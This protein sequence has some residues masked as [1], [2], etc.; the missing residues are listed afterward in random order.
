MTKVYVK[1][2]STM[3]KDI[4]IYKFQKDDEKRLACWD[5]RLCKITNKDFNSWYNAVRDQRTPC[6]LIKYDTTK[7]LINGVFQQLTIK[8]Y[9]AKIINI[10]NTLKKETNGKINMY[11]SGRFSKT[12]LEFYFTE[13][14]NKYDIELDHISYEEAIII[15]KAS[16]GPL[17]ISKKCLNIKAWSYDF[18]SCYPSIMR[19][20]KMLFP[21]KE[22]KWVFLNKDEF[23]N[24][25]FYQ[26]GIY[27]VKILKSED[28]SINQLFKFNNDNWYTHID[29]NLAKDLGLELII[30]QKNKQNFLYYKRDSLISG[31][32][33]FGEYIN[34]MFKLKQKDIPGGKELIKCLWGALCKANIARVKFNIND[35]L[36]L[37]HNKDYDTIV[38]INNNEYIADI[39]NKAQYF[40][41]DLARIKPFLL[42]KG[43][44]K[45]SKAIYP[46]KENILYS[47]TDSL[48]VDID[49]SKN[50]QLLKIFGNDIGDLAY[51]GLYENFWCNNITSKT[52]KIELIK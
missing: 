28:N 11:K 39:Y 10:A 46:V 51:E 2:I 19:D 40:D 14:F 33:L 30:K 27:N 13:Y 12:A 16:I 22:G 26:Y 25:K 29:L 44:F 47:H 45:L 48:I 4:V 21:I 52:S 7:V 50:K 9:Y 3:E 20:S 6:L 15:Q 35:E 43:R 49:I 36:V 8:E 34:F 23:N 41:Y 1:N 32:D 5:N 18:K 38:P 31:K 37:K 24:L 17:L 42:A